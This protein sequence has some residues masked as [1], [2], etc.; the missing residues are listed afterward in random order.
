MP[1]NVISW[2]GGAGSV[3]L[4]AILGA[5]AFAH[6]EIT[7]KFDPDRPVS[8]TGTVTKLDWLNPHVHIFFDVTRGGQAESW[9]VEL[10][11]PID[12]AGGGWT[13]ESLLPGD[14]IRVTGPAARDGSRQ[15]WGDSVVLTSSGRPVFDTVGGPPRGAR[16]GEVPRWPDGQPRLGPP[17]GETGYWGNPSATSLVERGVEVEMNEQ[18]LL[19][20]IADA[21]R[22]APLQ[23][24]ALALY[25]ERQRTFLVTDPTFQLCIPPGGPRL[26]QAPYGIQ[27]A[28]DRPRERIFVLP[29]GGNRNWKLIYLDGREQVG[30]VGGDDDN[31][32]F[33]GRSVA[34][35]EGDTLVVDTIGFNEKF[36][37]S[38]GGLP[39]T[40][41]LHMVER[42]TRTDLGT[43]EYEVTI[44][45]P[46]AYT[47][48]WTAE[49][50]LQWIPGEE[51]P[52]Y[53]C[54][55]NRP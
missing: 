5:S 50:T 38:N 23:P 32:L 2:A 51:M 19:A 41:A 37:I 29:G 1:R 45:D 7:A 21:P 14:E 13:R 36:W 24:W 46:G 55:D 17:Q 10:Q 3:A 27:F 25:E 26:Y 9:A 6:H 44:E 54:Q 40:E 22:V 39:H 33:L 52:V 4:L 53:Y 47:R 28:E 48:P 34:E 35:W 31:P 43:L 42:L 16:G 49:W 12:L 18:G 8:L 11:S 30:Q 20:D 15:V